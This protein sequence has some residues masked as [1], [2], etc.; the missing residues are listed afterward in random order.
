DGGSGRWW[1]QSS[2]VGPLTVSARDRSILRIAFGPASGGP[3]VGE[4]LVD[5]E[6][7]REEPVAAELDAYFAGALRSFPVAPDWTSVSGFRRDVLQALATDV[8]YG[9]TV[10]YGE[11]A[12][13]VGRPGA[14]RAVGTA[15]A[16]NPFPIVVPCHRVVRA[17][18]VLG[19]FGPG[20]EAKRT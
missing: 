17:G 11:L 19:H 8:P 1:I 10:S 16:T 3:P 5:P 15:M 4:V 7:A 9:E 12:A 20:P 13:M 18:G 14:A 6:P 2:P